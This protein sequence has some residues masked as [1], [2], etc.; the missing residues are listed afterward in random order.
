MAVHQSVPLICWANAWA[1][2]AERNG[3][4]RGRDVAGCADGHSR[5]L[6]GSDGERNGIGNA[7][8]GGGDLRVA[9]AGVDEGDEGIGLIRARFAGGVGLRVGVGAVIHGDG[10]GVS[11]AGGE[12]LV[13]DGGVLGGD[14]VVIGEVLIDERE[15]VARLDG[16][17]GPATRSKW[18]A[19]AVKVPLCSMQ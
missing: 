12:K 14:D 11:G 19:A 3:A 7:A 5:G 6:A 13:F 9:R 1:T 15:L 18:P 16:P 2:V 10:V 17:A 4:E 8:D